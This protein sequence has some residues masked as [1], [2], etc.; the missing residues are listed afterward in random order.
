LTDVGLNGN[1]LVEIGS[2]IIEVLSW[3]LSGRTGWGETLTTSVMTEILRFVSLI[4]KLIF[5][6]QLNIELNASLKGK[7]T[8]SRWRCPHSKLFQMY[9][10]GNDFLFTYNCLVLF[11]Q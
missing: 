6:K 7:Q 10:T 9:F 8:I 1:Y 11:T 5:H 4:F 3:N 2:E